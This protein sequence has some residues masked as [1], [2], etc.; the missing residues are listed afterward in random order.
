MPDVD[1]RTLGASQH[2]QQVAMKRHHGLQR[3][4]CVI[5]TF[6]HLSQR[7]ELHDAEFGLV[8]G[9]QRQVLQPAGARHR[10]DPHGAAAHGQHV[11]DHQLVDLAG[12]AAGDAQVAVRG[13]AL[14]V[15]RR[16]GVQADGGNH[17]QEAA[18]GE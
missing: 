1:H 2:M 10:A 18:E 5:A 17:E 15:G 11:A 12:R 7:V 14:G 13:R 4:Q 9:D 16:D 3:L 8:G 6:L